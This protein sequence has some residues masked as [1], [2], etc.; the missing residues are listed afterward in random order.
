MDDFLEKEDRALERLFQ[1]NPE[2]EWMENPE[3]GESRPMEKEMGAAN[4]EE[5]DDK[6]AEEEAEEEVDEGEGEVELEEADDEEVE[7]EEAH[8]KE[9]QLEDAHDKEVELE[10]AD[11]ED[12]ELEEVDNEEEENVEN[13]SAAKEKREYL[14]VRPARQGRCPKSVG[15]RS[16]MHIPR[17]PQAIANEGP[18]ERP[19][20]GPRQRLDARTEILNAKKN[21][22]RVEKPS[23]RKDKPR[24]WNSTTRKDRLE[25]LQML[26]SGKEWGIQSNEKGEKKMLLK[27]PGKMSQRRVGQILGFDESQIRRWK[28]EQKNILD[29]PTGKRKIGSTGRRVQWPE[30]EE[31]LA[32]LW[33]EQV[34]DGLAI[35]RR[36]FGRHAMKIFDEQYP[37]EVAIVDGETVRSFAW[38]FPSKNHAS[39]NMML[40]KYL[41]RLSDG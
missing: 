22:H 15:E 26:D 3:P 24:R 5:A 27:G 2:D 11:D 41:D 14:G 6:E 21:L 18:W 29:A 35:S 12:V 8:D 16:R 25:A 38:V 10:R 7:L 37:N 34:G 9:E 32:K 31:Q 4:E 19:P 30:L 1:Q 13:A 20:R 40:T 36:W 33:K 39:T 17:L 23:L 28:R